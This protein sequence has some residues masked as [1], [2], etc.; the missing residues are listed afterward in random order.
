MFPGGAS[1]T[2]AKLSTV[3]V[4]DD[5]AQT[6]IQGVEDASDSAAESM[7]EAEDASEGLSSGLQSVNKSALAASGALTAAGAAAQGAFDKTRDT[8]AELERTAA[9]TGMTRD[10]V[11]DLTSSMTDATF[12]QEEAVAVMGDLREAN[13]ETSEDMEN[14]ALATDAVADATGISATKISGDLLPA[15]ESMGGETEDLA[16]NKDLLI[17]VLA[18]TRA[19]TGEFSRVLRSAGDDVRGLGMDTEE[20]MVVYGALAQR[21]PETADRTSTFQDAV[22]TANEQNRDLIPVLNETSD[23][24]DL[25]AD[26][27]EELEDEVRESDEAIE[28]AVGAEEEAAT[29]T[30]EL[31]HRVRV[32]GREFAEFTQPVSAVAPL[33]M[34]LGGA[35]MFATSAQTALAGSTTASTAA[36][37]GKTIALGAASKAQWLMTASTTS[38]TTATRAKTASMWASVGGLA[39]STKATLAGASAKGV[40]T[41]ATLTAA[42]A[43]TSLWAATGPLGLAV[44]G[45][46][47]GTLALAGVMRTDLFGAG[48]QAARVLGGVRDA[49]TGT[50]RIFRELVGIGYEVGR[51]GAMIAGLSLIAPFAAAIRF[52]EDP[53]RWLSAGAQIPSMV[54]SG[55]ADRASAPV[56]AISGVMS[57]VRSYLPFSPAETGPLQDLDSTGAEIVRMIG[58]GI[59]DGPDVGE[60]LRGKLSGAVGFL[61]SPGQWASAGASLAT[62]V[63]GGIRDRAPDVSGAVE[64]AVSGA[65]DRLPFSPAQEGPLEDIDEA[66]NSLMQTVAGGIHDE[67]GAVSG[68][69]ST[70]LGAVSTLPGLSANGGPGGMMGALASPTPAG[71]DAPSGSES[72]QRPIKVEIDSINQD[73]DVHGGGDADTAEAVGQ[74]AEGGVTDGVDELME[75]ISR[76]L[77]D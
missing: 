3:M 26:S 21:I 27:Y 57:D 56:D 61:T 7:E 42:G 31:R 16:E 55:I 49:A 50:V 19:E 22:Q 25:Q 36:M 20:L 33:M 13:V 63:A 60:F 10:E 71:G 17:S 46:T 5:Q 73:I 45:L 34:G 2:I 4:A 12:T 37:K 48:D 39:A 47:A 9:M 72:G 35:A 44:L 53:G 51:I 75:E 38:L 65:R 69:L 30:D 67:E 32:L 14:L 28:Q 66:G 11:S 41:G 54:A 8:R 24:L 77:D 58:S 74:Q 64:G 6:E 52:L 18:G 59:L 70:A 68:A 40:L 1:G 62:S 76:E 29:V 23:Q 15:I 43:M